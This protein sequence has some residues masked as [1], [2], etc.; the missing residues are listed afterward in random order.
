MRWLPPILIVL[1]LVPR[2][3]GEERLPLIGD[4]PDISAKSYYPSAGWPK[5]IGALGPI[6]ALTLT[7]RDPAFGG[8]SAIRLRQG[9]AV[10][11]GDGGNVVTFRIN[12]GQ[13]EDARGHVLRD[14]PA[15]G[16]QRQDRDSESLA[17]DPVRGI[18]WVG[19]ENN[20]RIWRYAPDFGWGEAQAWPKPMRTWPNNQSIETLIRLRDGRFIAIA[21][22]GPR[23]TVRPALIFSGD[24]TARGT[25]IARFQFS[26]PE[27]YDPT[28]GAELPDG[29][30][31]ILNRRFQFP[32]R[33]TAKVVRIAR[34]DIRAGTIAKGRV[35]ATL[36][37]PVVS[38]NA[39]GIEVTREG[40]A[41]MVWIVTDNDGM[42][43]R[44]TFLMKF[45][46]LD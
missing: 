24:P 36:A 43:W 25:S 6:G 23:R 44:P 34:D 28:D 37:D 35:I 2:Y 39:E 26:P 38:E 41:T 33:F 12:G 7:S 15:I 45:R 13:V 42:F 18:A 9:R 1:L 32:F 16:W 19:Y 4:R 17:I 31:L 27:G 5:R 10:L 14:G 3:A 40:R 29:D 11:L 21:E 30:L 22:R 8:F 46:L 20:D